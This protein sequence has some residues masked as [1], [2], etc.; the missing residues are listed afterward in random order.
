MIHVEAARMLFFSNFHKFARSC[1]LLQQK[2]DPRRTDSRSVQS[3]G[4]FHFVRRD[5]QFLKQARA[6]A[7]LRLSCRLLRLKSLT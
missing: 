6:G 2:A 1:D 5:D 4:K 7:V 3:S